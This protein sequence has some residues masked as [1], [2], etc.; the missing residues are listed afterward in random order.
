MKKILLFTFFCV[1]ALTTFASHNRA[2]EITYK[3]VSGYTYEITV[4]TYTKESSTLADKCSL[5]INFGDSQS[6][7]FSRVNGLASPSSP[8]GA[9]PMGEPLGNDIKKKHIHW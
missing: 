7:T 4:T 1:I 2:G 9:T 3:H 5:T 8:C 6:A